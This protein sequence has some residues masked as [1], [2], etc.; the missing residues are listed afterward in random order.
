LLLLAVDRIAR[1]PV[2]AS[3]AHDHEDHHVDRNDGDIKYQIDESLA[4][5]LA[6]W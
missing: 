1:N 3:A 4:V 2:H 5:A 6:E